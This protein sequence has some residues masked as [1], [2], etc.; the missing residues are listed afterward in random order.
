MDTLL[1]IVL[2]AP[3]IA[4]LL[5]SVSN[6]TADMVCGNHEYYSTHKLTNHGVILSYD[7]CITLG[8]K[9][10]DDQKTNFK[11]YGALWL[12]LLF[13]IDY[14]VMK[15]INSNKPK[16]TLPKTLTDKHPNYCPV[17]RDALGTFTHERQNLR[18]EK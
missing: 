5:V 2:C 9:T 3:P 12:G 11:I 7:E 16:Y 1:K 8:N 14:V 13:G 15:I 17:G 6:I 18:D 10:I 4:M